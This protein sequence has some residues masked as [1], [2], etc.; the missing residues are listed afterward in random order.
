MSRLVINLISSIA[1]SVLVGSVLL[2]TGIMFENLWP[3]RVL[4][5]TII[6][7]LEL[8]LLLLWIRPNFD[9]IRAEKLKI[10]KAHFKEMM[11]EY[12]TEKASQP[13]QKDDLSQV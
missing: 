13:H 1:K 5:F 4:T 3:E 11:A 8:G 10:E 12:E 6:A 7:I 9:A 2:F